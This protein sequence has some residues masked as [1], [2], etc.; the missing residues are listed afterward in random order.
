M[1]RIKLKEGTQLR[2]YGKALTSLAI[3]RDEA[4]DRLGE[5]QGEER[6]IWE[7]VKKILLT[8]KLIPK[9]Y[10]NNFMRVHDTLELEVLD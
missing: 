4:W 9:I 10:I 7:K 2:K 6:E 3:Q 5:I 8:S 1:K